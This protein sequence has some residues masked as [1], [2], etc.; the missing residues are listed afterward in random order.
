[1]K[2]K[3]TWSGLPPTLPRNYK[4]MEFYAKCLRKHKYYIK[5]FH[6]YL[7]YLLAKI[8]YLIKKY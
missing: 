1:M 8:K 5:S 4:E 6:W 2:T 3:P 7:K